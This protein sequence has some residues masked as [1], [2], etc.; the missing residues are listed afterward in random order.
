MRRTSAPRATP[1]AVLFTVALVL[2]AAPASGYQLF[3]LDD[4]GGASV[5]QEIELRFNGALGS[6]VAVHGW[7]R[8]LSM[9]PR[10]AKR[11]IAKSMTLCVPLIAEDIE[12]FGAIFLHY[13]KFQTMM[14]SEVIVAASGMTRANITSL[15]LLLR[16]AVKDMPIL[17]GQDIPALV[18]GVAEPAMPGANRNRC[19]EHSNSE[20]ITFFDSDDAMDP[21]RTEIID[22]VF[23]RY[24]PK[25]LVHD[26]VSGNLKSSFGNDFEVVAATTSTYNNS[27]TFDRIASIAQGW[28]TVSREIFSRVR[29]N[30]TRR[31]GEDIQFLDDVMKAYGGKPDKS[32]LVAVR[33]PLGAYT[34]R[35]ERKT[36][37]R[38]EMAL[39]VQV[40]EELQGTLHLAEGRSAGAGSARAGPQGEAR[41]FTKPAWWRPPRKSA[42]EILAEVGL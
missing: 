36:K 32:T 23:Q 19:A 6:G 26:Y 1:V 10:P 3:R 15:E 34:P 5:E 9:P 11:T 33:L 8:N 35:S 42:K 21:R 38:R 20:V 2:A 27:G 31:E 37:H 14:P 40:L 41:R 13:L 17:V 12:R 24:L 16:R 30:E 29:Y 39:A 22:Y 28:T 7:S 25:V 4:A 18:L